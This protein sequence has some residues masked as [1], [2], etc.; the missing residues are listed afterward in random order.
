MSTMN[1]SKRSPLPTT[2][3]G[4]RHGRTMS[5]DSST[6]ERNNVKNQNA[7]PHSTRRARF[8]RSTLLVL[9]IVG[10]LTLRY[11][12][13]IEHNTH[14]VGDIVVKIDDTITTPLHPEVDTIHGNDHFYM[15][16][17]A[18][19]TTDGKPKGILLY[20]H[21]CKQS[22]L[23]F[24]GLPEHR[25]I[26]KVATE[27]GLV[28]FS[29]TSHNRIS[30]C[31]TSEDANGYLEKVFVKFQR[32]HKLR[33]LPRVGLGDSSGGAFLSFVHKELKLDSM[34]VYNSPQGYGDMV[35]E[36]NV[37][38]P[39]VYLTMST[40]TSIMERMNT[41]M[42]RLQKLNISSSLYKVSPRPFTKSLC[43]ARLP[44]IGGFCEHI[45]KIIERDHSSLLDTDGYVLEGD[46][47]SAQW[48]RCF[49]KLES[50]YKILSKGAATDPEILYDSSPQATRS[51]L[52]VI[53]EQEIQTCYGFHA[54]TAQFHDEIIEFLIS[55]SAME[56][57]PL[58]SY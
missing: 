24:F 53:L 49:E 36:Y 46:V 35:N 34:A 11:P 40:D 12:S 58:P 52:T 44:E 42:E 18:N 26:A 3:A 5:A 31:Y 6:R 57:N 14:S 21:S 16:P 50:D 2:T 15:F 39:T 32:S 33:G 48:Q 37:A 54:M 8:L 45:F 9:A 10:L 38:I 23:E 20:L 30:G 41:D 43:A 25:I 27:K 29:P 13:F 28:V 17:P 1:K 19:A 56:E 47:K 22:G 55:N 51:W 7:N 4:A